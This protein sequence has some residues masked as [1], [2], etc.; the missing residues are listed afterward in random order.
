MEPDDVTADSGEAS[1]IDGYPYAGCKRNQHR[2][3]GIT[4]A[5]HKLRVCFY[6]LFPEV[7]KPKNQIEYQ[8]QQSHGGERNRY[9]HIKGGTVLNEPRIDTAEILYRLGKI[10]KQNEKNI[11]AAEDGLA[12]RS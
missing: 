2:D 7:L 11:T 1:S 12:S 6:R 3:H 10:G 4:N 8:E 9:D 5:K